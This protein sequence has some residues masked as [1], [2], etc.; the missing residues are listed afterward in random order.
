[1]WRDSDF[2]I[3]M[4]KIFDT[5]LTNL[6]ENVIFLYLLITFLF[7][8][9][10]QNSNIFWFL[11]QGFIR[12][13]LTRVTNCFY[14]D[15]LQNFEFTKSHFF[16]SLIKII[17]PNVQS[18][19]HAYRPTYCFGNIYSICNYAL[20]NLFANLNIFFCQKNT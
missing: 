5:I 9:G 10:F 18:Y 3:I 11:L 7:I 16:I 14:K 6:N 12:L 4:R 1:M 20:L 19:I 2:K 15:F 8:T 17:H 13:S